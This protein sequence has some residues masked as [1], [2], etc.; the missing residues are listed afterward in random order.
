[1]QST[2]WPIMRFQYAVL[3]VGLSTLILAPPA[4]V[5]DDTLT[6][7]DQA[8]E[9]GCAALRPLLHET[10]ITENESAARN[11]ADNDPSCREIRED[12]HYT[13]YESAPS[14]S[15]IFECEKVVGVKVCVGLFSGGCSLWLDFG[16]TG[17]MSAMWERL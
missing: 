16:F 6:P 5:A 8:A 12:G 17:C 4:V 15:R 1:M 10:E 13:V 7:V 3:V 11:A 14:S 9:P 2:M